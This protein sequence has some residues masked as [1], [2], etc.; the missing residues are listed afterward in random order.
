MSLEESI[1]KIVKDE[2]EKRNQK[3]EL[4][5]VADFCKDKNLSRI[6]I[7]RG[8]KQGKFKLTRIGRKVFINP[9]QFIT[10]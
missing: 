6:T 1:R 9:Q 10:A 8:E 4:V 7:W 5:P 2:I 3:T